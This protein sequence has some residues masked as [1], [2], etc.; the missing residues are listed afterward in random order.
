[1]F[2]QRFQLISTAHITREHS[3]QRY[4]AFHQMMARS[5]MIVLLRHF[6]GGQHL[7]SQLIQSTQ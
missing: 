3:K 7:V 4:L 2:T 5:F 6:H 1:M